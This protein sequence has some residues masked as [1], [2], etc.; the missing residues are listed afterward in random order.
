MDHIPAAIAHEAVPVAEA[1]LVQ[2]ARHEHPGALART[3]TMLLARLDP[4]GS[5]PD[6][7]DLERRRGFTLVKGRDG[8]AQVRAVHPEVTAQWEAILDSL[9]AP[10]PGADGPD[11]RSPAQ[12]RHDA[13]GEA[14]GRLLRSGNLPATG[15]VPVTVLLR[16]TA[17][18]LHADSGVGADRA[19]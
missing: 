1:L 17:E 4:D 11:D 18:D 2:A 5:R 9:A 19:R 7:R 13:L 15:G 16:T 6:E 3:A 8:S 14:A 12:R 10:V